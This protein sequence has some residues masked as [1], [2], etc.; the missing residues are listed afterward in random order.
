MCT[1]LLTSLQ[2]PQAQ[3]HTPQYGRQSLSPSSP[4]PGPSCHCP[5][6]MA[7]HWARPRDT[8]PP[9]LFNMYFSSS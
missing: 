5:Q 2:W 9:S 4:S 8:Y 7:P 6:H 1:L 3:V